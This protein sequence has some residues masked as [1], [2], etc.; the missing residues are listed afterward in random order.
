MQ[1]TDFVATVFDGESHPDKATVAFTMALKAAEK[2]HSATI[3]LMAQA[4][5][6]GKPGGA[7]GLDI[8]APFRP[9][10]DLMSDYLEQGGTIAVCGACMKHNGLAESDLDDRFPVINADDVVDL[11]MNA[12]GGLQVT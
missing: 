12:R 3:I 6:L 10:A 4:V 2:G 7:A 8:G 9:V 11:V 1:T 5:H